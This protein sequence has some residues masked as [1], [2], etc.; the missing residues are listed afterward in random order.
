MFIDV[1]IDSMVR[2]LQSEYMPFDE[3]KL[4]FITNQPEHLFF[5]S[6]VVGSV[7]LKPNNSLPLK[8]V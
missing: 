2:P 5:S 4:E 8:P 1:L 7:H 3:T 6:S